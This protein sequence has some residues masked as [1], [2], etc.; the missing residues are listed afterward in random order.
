MEGVKFAV[1]KILRIHF[2]VVHTVHVSAL[3][4][5]GYLLHVVYADTWNYGQ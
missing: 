4:F 1:D 5:L 2:Q 3:A